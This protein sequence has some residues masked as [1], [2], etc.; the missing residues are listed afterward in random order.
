[1]CRPEVPPQDALWTIGEIGAE[2]DFLLII[3]SQPAAL[4]VL[5]HAPKFPGS[6]IWSKIK[7]NGFLLRLIKL[8]KLKMDKLVSSN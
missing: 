7:M 2:F 8:S 3:R 4:A 6:L 5:I 1:M